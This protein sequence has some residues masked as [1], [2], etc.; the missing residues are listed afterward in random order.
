MSQVHHHGWQVQALSPSSKAGQANSFEAGTLEGTQLTGSGLT[1]QQPVGALDYTDPFVD[2]TTSTYHVAHWT[3]P[4]MASDFAFHELVSSW[5]ARTPPGTWVELSARVAPPGSSESSQCGDAAEGRTNRGGGQA[6]EGDWFVLGR[7][8]DNTSTIHRTTLP[9]QHG[10]SAYVDCDVLTAKDEAGFGS[11]QLRVSLHRAADT[12]ATPYVLSVEAVVSRW[13]V[14][15]GERSASQRPSVLPPTDSAA[16][17][18]VLDVPT[19]SQTLHRGEYPQ[20]NAGGEAWCSPTSTAMVL[21]YWRRGPSPADY[22]WVDSTYADPWVDHAAACTFDYGYDGCGN[23]SFNVAY[24]ARFGLIARV[25]RLRSLEEAER[26][27][28]AGVPLIA[29]VSFADGGLTGAGYSTN[30]HL[31][32][33]VGFTNDGDVVVNDP[34]SHLVASNDE[35]RTSYNREEF[36]R[37]WLPTSGGTVYV[38]HPP[39]HPIVT[40]GQAR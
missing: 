20:L 18:T 2:G 39:E 36:E 32:V 37:V 11:W 1:L 33:L 16:W 14:A 13:A 4:L 34:A 5:S 24:A 9:G 35:V 26:F 17:G 8:A 15:D 40:E 23:W 6:D 7:W 12:D 10:A 22:A 25:T 19:Y 38:I 30:G 3:S 31:L 28:A 29:S 27:I 21:A